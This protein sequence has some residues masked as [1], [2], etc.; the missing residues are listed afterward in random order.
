MTVGKLIPD[1]TFSE[2]VRGKR[3]SRAYQGVAEIVRNEI[4]QLA[5]PAIREK[6]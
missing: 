4:M 3:R 2:A 6:R 1:E 5:D